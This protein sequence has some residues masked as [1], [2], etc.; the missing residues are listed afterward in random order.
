MKLDLD[1]ANVREVEITREE[2]RAYF[3]AGELPDEVE[4]ALDE[5]QGAANLPGATQYLVIKITG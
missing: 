3:D 2:A 5:A 4:T 1:A